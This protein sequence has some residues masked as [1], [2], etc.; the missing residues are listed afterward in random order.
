MIFV[1]V[2]LDRLLE[3]L[4]CLLLMRQTNAVTLVDVTMQQSTDQ[5]VALCIMPRLFLVCINFT[6]FLQN[7]ICIFIGSTEI[8]TGSI[9]LEDGLSIIATV[10]ANPSAVYTFTN[11]YASTPSVK[12]CLPT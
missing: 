11:L 1:L 12:I 6:Y 2:Y 7:S 3:L 9:S 4:Y 5:L 10:T 8:P